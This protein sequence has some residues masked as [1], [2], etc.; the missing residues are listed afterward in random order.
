[1]RIIIK[2]NYDAK[3]LSAPAKNF[4]KKKSKNIDTAA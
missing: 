2:E 4:K 1:M 3:L